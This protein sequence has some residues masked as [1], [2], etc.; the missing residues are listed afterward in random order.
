PRFTLVV[1]GHYDK[2]KLLRSLK[3]EAKPHGARTLY[4]F[5]PEGLGFDVHFW[6]PDDQTIVLCRAKED[7][8]GVP[9]MLSDGQPGPAI[10]IHYPPLIGRFNADLQ[11]VFQEDLPAG[12]TVWLAGAIRHGEQVLDPL[13]QF[14]IITQNDV[15]TFAP[16]QRLGAW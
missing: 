6:L 3:A 4:S 9:S 15:A 1:R 5:Q 11:K 14:G 16:L 13:A 8:D 7:F 12:A 2:G 10:T